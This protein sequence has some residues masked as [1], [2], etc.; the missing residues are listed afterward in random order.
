MARCASVDPLGFHN[1]SLGQDSII[2]KYDDSKS[3]K[4]GERLSEKNVYA[5]TEHYYLCF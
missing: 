5:N 4:D 3:D 2:V 1:F